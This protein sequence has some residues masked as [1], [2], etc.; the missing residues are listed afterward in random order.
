[1]G[2][3][4]NHVLSNMPFKTSSVGNESYVLGHFDE[5]KMKVLIS[6]LVIFIYEKKRNRC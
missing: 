2:I 5:R 4:G 6:F 3:L 1:M